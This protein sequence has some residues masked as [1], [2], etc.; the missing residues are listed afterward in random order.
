M[1]FIRWCCQNQQFQHFIRMLN[2]IICKLVRTLNKIKWN[3]YSNLSVNV[4]ENPIRKTKWDSID[5]LSE[6]LYLLRTLLLLFDVTRAVPVRREQKCNK[7]RK[8]N[9]Q[10]SSCL[11]AWGEEAAVSANRSGAWKMEISPDNTILGLGKSHASQGLWC[12]CWQVCEKLQ[13]K[14]IP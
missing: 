10:V 13:R 7:N 3:L 1:Y 6:C 12:I 2:S 4:Y 9:P 11:T 5:Y 8:K 14:S